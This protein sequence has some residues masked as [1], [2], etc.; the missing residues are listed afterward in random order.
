MVSVI[1]PAYN[2]ERYI[3]KCIKS[4]LDQSYTDTEIIIVD[5]GSTD[6]T[7]KICRDLEKDYNRIR[8]ICQ[9]NRGVSVARNTGIRE[10]G[11]EY[12]MFVDGD[13]FIEPE[14]ID[15]LMERS[16]EGFDIVCCCCRTAG[17]ESVYEDH[18]FDGDRSFCTDVE[19]EELFLQLID[20]RYGKGSKRVVTAIGVPWGKLYRSSLI[21]SKDILFDPELKR[22]QDNMFNMHAF[23]EAGRIFYLDQPLYDYRIDHIVGF[24]SG[25]R[26]PG[27]SEKLIRKR[28]KFF[29]DNKGFYTE[30]AEM[31]FNKYIY[32]SFMAGLKYYAS[33]SRTY[34]KNIRKSFIEMKD[35]EI[36]SG[37]TGTVFSGKLK[38]EKLAECLI[39]Y[40]MYLLLFIVLRMTL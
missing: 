28:K 19:K 21:R 39:K 9:E 7:G 10:A 40:K 23:A 30:K 22:L 34:N 1:I 12:L 36:Y 26:Y 2:V 17:E 13:D 37:C 18:F 33:T 25:Y 14:L 5:D 6:G 24:H 16:R 27:N 35:K 4:I 3:E 11:G 20:P 8:Y 32:R 38:H 15:R 29:E 31:E